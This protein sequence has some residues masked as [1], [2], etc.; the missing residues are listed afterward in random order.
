MRQVS[1]KRR[2]SIPILAV[3][4][5]AYLAGTTAQAGC[6]NLYGEL[7]ERAQRAVERFNAADRS[8][9]CSRAEDLLRV[10]QRLSRFVQDYQVQ[11]VIDQEIIDVQTRRVRKA[12]EA[13]SR[14]CDR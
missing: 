14:A 2:R 8:R 7:D 1:R 10:E 5:S 9:A 3:L 13:Q 4:A 6:P 12:R 11:C